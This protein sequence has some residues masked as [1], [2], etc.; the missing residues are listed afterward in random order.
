MNKDKARSGVYAM[1]GAYLL[2]M[3]YQIFTSRTDSAGVEYT[4]MIIF[5]ILFLLLGL[6]LIGFSLYMMKKK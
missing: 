6:G 1:A 4:I 5:S 2:Y 3:A